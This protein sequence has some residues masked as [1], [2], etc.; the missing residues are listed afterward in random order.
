[1]IFTTAMPANQEPT[2]KVN[3]TLLSAPNKV[4]K[5]YDLPVS[6]I[7]DGSLFEVLLDL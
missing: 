1:M 7:L 5:I 2:V 4:G 6:L 3:V